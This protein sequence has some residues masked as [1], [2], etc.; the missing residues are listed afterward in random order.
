MQNYSLRYGKNYSYRYRTYLLSLPGFSVREPGDMATPVSLGG[1]EESSRLSS[2]SPPA[3]GWGGGTLGGGGL[4]WS[5][6]SDDS[7]GELVLRG[8]TSEDE[9]RGD[10]E[11]VFCLSSTVGARDRAP[12]GKSKSVTSNTTTQSHH[13]QVTQT[14]HYKTAQ[15]T[16]SLS[17]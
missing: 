9:P 5:C 15:R 6:S 17:K 13:Y 4:G 8:S 3:G 2:A 7:L 10:E 14:S 16:N 1:V 11:S 12:P